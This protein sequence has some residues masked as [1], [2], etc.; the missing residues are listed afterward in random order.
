MCGPIN[1]MMLAASA[2]ASISWVNTYQ[3][4]VESES[5]TCKD[6]SHNKKVWV[7]SASRQYDS[8]N[9]L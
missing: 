2:E 8:G 6:T 5:V 9:L 1:Y 7:F 4:V 3:L